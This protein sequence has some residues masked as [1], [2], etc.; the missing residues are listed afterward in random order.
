MGHSYETCLLKCG[1]GACK[2]QSEMLQFDQG[3][4]QFDHFVTDFF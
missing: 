2:A 1:L 3:D 4:E